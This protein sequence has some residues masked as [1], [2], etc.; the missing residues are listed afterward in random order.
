MLLAL[1]RLVVGLLGGALALLWFEMLRAMSG[2]PP[3]AFKLS[4]E[5]ALLNV[6]GGAGREGG[7]A[8]IPIGGADVVLVG[9]VLA[10]RGGGG[11]AVLAAV[12]SAP[13]FLLTQRFRS[14][15]YT[16]L[17]AS[18]NLALMGLFGISAASF[19]PPPNH[20]PKPQPFFFAAFASAVR[21][22]GV[23]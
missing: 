11:V 22:A 15:S 23:C 4:W 1:L 16:K 10:A 12:F 7:G 8:M 2:A 5:I 20:P 17:L 19:L 3:G 21:F 9:G 13:D 14:G 6:I 18:P